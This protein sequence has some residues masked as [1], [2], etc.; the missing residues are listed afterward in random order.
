[1]FL[2]LFYCGLRVK[3][4][5]HGVKKNHIIMWHKVLV[6]YAM[7]VLELRNQFAHHLRLIKVIALLV[8]DLPGFT[9]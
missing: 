4:D 8:L 9:D 2:C 5:W 7:C 1:M 6:N 3:Y